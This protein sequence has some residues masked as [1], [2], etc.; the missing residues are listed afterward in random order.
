M[1]LHHVALIVSDYEKS[2]AFYTRVL[3]FVVLAEHYR[4]ERDSWKLDLALD[5]EYVLELF[6]FP[7]PPPRA[8]WPEACGLRHLALAVA[9][10]VGERAALL[11]KGVECEVLRTDSCTGKRFFFFRDP[12]GL[13]I[14]FYEQ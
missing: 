7:D 13:P 1:K 3:P 2:K 8:R 9:D 10:I 11:A 14:E 5:G 6:S 4:A 12:D